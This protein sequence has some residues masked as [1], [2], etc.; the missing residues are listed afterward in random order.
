M[1]L[2]PVSHEIAEKTALEWENYPIDSASL[3]LEEIK[4]ILDKT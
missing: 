3:H 2:N 1:E 4:K